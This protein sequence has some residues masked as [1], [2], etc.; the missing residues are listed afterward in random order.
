MSTTL[1]TS[2]SP[3][4][5]H[6]DDVRARRAP[7]RRRQRPSPS[8]ARPAAPSPMARAQERLAGRRRRAAGD[9]AAASSGRRRQ[10]TIAVLRPFRKPEARIDDQP[11]DGDAGR[12]RAAASRPAVRVRP[13]R[14]TSR[15]VPPRDTSSSS[16]RACASVRARRRDGATTAP[17]A[18]SYLSPLTSFTIGRRPPARRGH[19]RL[20]GVDGDGHRQAAGQRVRRPGAPAVVPRLRR[21]ARRRDGSI[22]RRCR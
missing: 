9:P 1:T 17:S 2:P 22:R 15:V 4:R 11:L 14:P 19:R 10:H 5:V 20:V 18:G 6:A 3:R 21:R 13:P 12:R 7:R 8:R 16:G